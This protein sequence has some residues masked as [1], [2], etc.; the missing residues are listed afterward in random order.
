MND[1]TPDHSHDRNGASLYEILRG[2]GPKQL[3]AA[4]RQTL[5]EF[6]REQLEAMKR[7]ANSCTHEEFEEFLAV[8]LQTSSRGAAASLDTG[9][10]W[11]PGPTTFNPD[12]PGP[13]TPSN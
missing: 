5:G 4:D 9:D 11:G 12:A 7:I 8:G 2:L 13:E 10:C 1:S 6:S 3:E